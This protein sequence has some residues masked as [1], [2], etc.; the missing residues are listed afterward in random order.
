MTSNIVNMYNKRSNGYQSVIT[1]FNDKEVRAATLD[2]VRNATLVYY[3]DTFRAQKYE[4]DYGKFGYNNEYL[5]YIQKYRQVLTTSQF[6]NFTNSHPDET[7]ALIFNEDG[8]EKCLWA[9]DVSVE[10]QTV[11]HIFNNMAGAGS[12]QEIAIIKNKF[13]SYEWDEPEA[14]F[15]G[16]KIEPKTFHSAQYNEQVSYQFIFPDDTVQHYDWSVGGYYYGVIRL[17]WIN[18]RRD[19]HAGDILRKALQLANHT[20][21]ICC[22]FGGNN[23][24]FTNVINKNGIQDTLMRYGIHTADEDDRCHYDDRFHLDED[25]FGADDLDASTIERITEYLS[26]TLKNKAELEQDDDNDYTSATLLVLDKPMR[27]CRRPIYH[28][29]YGAKSG[30]AIDVVDLIRGELEIK[31]L[32]PVSAYHLAAKDGKYYRISHNF[33][34]YMKEKIA[35]TEIDQTSFEEWNSEKSI[36]PELL[37]AL[38]EYSTTELMLPM[39]RLLNVIPF[40]ATF[41]EQLIKTG[42]IELA[43]ELARKIGTEGDNINFRCYSLKDIFIGSNPEATSVMGVLDLSKPCYDFLMECDD[44]ASGNLNKF[45]TRYNAIK[46][47]IPDNIF[48]TAGSKMVDMYTYLNEKRMISFSGIKGGS[49]NLLDYPEEMKQIYKMMNKIPTKFSNPSLKDTA[50]TKY[51][52][53]VKVYFNLIIGEINPASELVFLEFGL[54]MPTE[55][56]VLDMLT[57]REKAANNALDNYKAKLDA[58]RRARLESQF[59]IRRKQVAKLETT[60]EFEKKRDYT[61]IAPSA[62]FGEDDCYSIEHEG[63]CMD[64]CVYRNYS[65]DIAEGKYTV[66]YLRHKKNP[67]DGWVTIGITEDGRINQ[68]Y[69]FHD[70]TI[71]PEA[72]Q[73]IVEWAESKAGLGTFKSEGRLISPGGWNYAVPLP[74]LPDVDKDWLKKLQTITE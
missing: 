9:Y 4:Q 2:D 13:G 65:T 18:H 5:F 63:K 51:K 15:E 35:T 70:R 39:V 25:P 6:V 73:A 28:L 32:I 29:F 27:G 67:E 16:L 24:K 69:T 23:Y 49:V 36:H 34:G 64:H 45:I 44:H 12:L 52:E 62:I 31:G 66:V 8:D 1:A 50:M 58:A 57:R 22:Y 56:E 26:T 40:G 11:I 21:V 74:K 7:F 72:A 41:I 19:S 20:R 33:F 71:S 55:A 60:K 68:T 14:L 47:F 54:G 30:D 61:V 53:I 10:N 46:R 37:K 59:A 42:H 3:K 43:C 17:H 38:A 48:T